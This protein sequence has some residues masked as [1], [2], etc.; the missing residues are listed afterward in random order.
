MTMMRA[1]Q[2]AAV[3]LMALALAPAPLQARDKNWYIG[4]RGGVVFPEKREFFAASPGLPDFNSTEKLGWAAAVRGGYDFGMLRTEI[5]VGYHQNNL[6]AIDLR[7]TTPL[8]AAGN[9]GSPA[10]KLRTGTIMANALI[11]FINT[12]SFSV[13]AG[14]GAGTAWVDA[15]NFRLAQ[16]GALVL[17]DSDWVFAWNALAGARVA[18]SPGVDLAVDYRYLRPNRARFSDTAGQAF[19]TRRNSHSIL[20][21]LNF[22]FG[23]KSRPA[24][25][26]EPAPSPMPVTPPPPPPPQPEYVPMPPPA[27]PIAPTAGPIILF[28]D[29]DRDIITPEARQLLDQVNDPSRQAGTSTL[30]V[31]GHTDRAGTVPYNEALGLRRAK[32]VQRQLEAMG[33]ERSRITIET[34]GESRS[35]V[36]TVDGQREPQNRRV[37]I[38]I[39]PR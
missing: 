38:T 7:S 35:L 19:N 30:R 32:A 37:E 3:G 33:I 27:A 23:P 24:A 17:S 10:G 31:E 2:L 12:D 5:D 14:A 4:L 22:N 20:V 1:Q 28:F 29:F 6:S 39:Q 18:L 15:H 16:T 34:Q 26:V 36:D 9:Y 21:G 11:D 13:S 25:V 8:G